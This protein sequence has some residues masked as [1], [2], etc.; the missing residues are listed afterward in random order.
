MTTA[1]TEEQTALADAWAA[2]TDIAKQ[3]PAPDVRV[4]YL[5][6]PGGVEE[7]LFLDT[8]DGS[9]EWVLCT[10][11]SVADERRTLADDDEVAGRGTTLLRSARQVSEEQEG[12]SRISPPFAN[13]IYALLVR[14]GADPAP[15]PEAVGKH[16]VL[17]PVN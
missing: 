13:G 5:E 9:V 2:Y 1:L 7:W 6:N 17:A 11:E 14:L 12:F 15:V 10:E 16:Y 8:R 3:Y 4:R